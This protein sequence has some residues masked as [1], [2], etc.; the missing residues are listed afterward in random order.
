MAECSLLGTNFDDSDEDEAEV[1]KKKKRTGNPRQVFLVC[2]LLWLSYGI[3]MTQVALETEWK[4]IC[5]PKS[6]GSLC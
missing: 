6:L 2:H 5:G 4:Q 3:P 1:E